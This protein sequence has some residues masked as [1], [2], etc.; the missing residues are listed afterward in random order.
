MRVSVSRRANRTETVE[1]SI[2]NRASVDMAI[3][4][5][6]QQTRLQHETRKYD[7]S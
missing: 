4:Q 6:Q 3:E 1:F 5:C 7:Q 2:L